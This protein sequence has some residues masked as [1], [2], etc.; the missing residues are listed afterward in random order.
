[1]A[2]TAL[3]YVTRLLFRGRI[4][5]YAAAMMTLVVVAF[6]AMPRLPLL[7]TAAAGWM[8][9]LLA[10]AR[11]SLRPAQLTCELDPQ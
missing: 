6:F 10:R 1:V 3:S 7:L 8:A 2:D 9:A 5:S 11:S 4:L